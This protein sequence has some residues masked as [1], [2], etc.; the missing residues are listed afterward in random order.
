MKR[1]IISILI[2]SICISLF[3]CNRIENDES[4]NEP[5]DESSAVDVSS[6]N[7]DVPF[8]VE[9][10]RVSQLMSMRKDALVQFSESLFDMIGSYVTEIP[11]DFFYPESDNEL[12]SLD[13]ACFHVLL[14]NAEYYKNLTAEYDVFLYD[15]MEKRFIE[16]NKAHSTIGSF[17]SSISAA[18]EKYADSF[19]GRDY[20]NARVILA[21]MAKYYLSI[22][23][24][25]SLQLVKATRSLSGDNSVLNAIPAYHPQKYL[26]LPY[27]NHVNNE[28]NSESAR[29]AIEKMY[30][31]SETDCLGDGYASA[32]YPYGSISICRYPVSYDTY[33]DLIIIDTSLPIYNMSISSV[34]GETSLIL[35]EYD[36]EATYYAER[37][38]FRVRPNCA[39]DS[40]EILPIDEENEE[41]TF[42]LYDE[43]GDEIKR[44]TFNYMTYVFRETY[45]A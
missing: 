22:E 19:A 15:T 28:K 7:P 3:A 30:H 12:P 23:N 38:R 34:S 33:D 16:E 44:I 6:E 39:F 37:S 10:V 13:D 4:S 42:V 14:S 32:L 9:N 18:T 43:S 20:E 29:A 35:D 40:A 25:V 17:V 26:H 27:I 45:P 5:K 8:D 1:T 31:S 21:H 41:V 36:E 2:I 11:D 24:T